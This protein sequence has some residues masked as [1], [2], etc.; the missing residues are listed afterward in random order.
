MC[1]VSSLTRNRHTL[2]VICALACIEFKRFFRGLADAGED[3]IDANHDTC[4]SLS[5][6]A[7]D[8]GDIARVLFE[9]FVLQ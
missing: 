1:D 8:S 7:M 5:C 3:Q 4:S 2:A 6:F 9:P